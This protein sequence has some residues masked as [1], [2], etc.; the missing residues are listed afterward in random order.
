MIITKVYD[1]YWDGTEMC[2][3]IDNQAI[4]ISMARFAAN[5]V[6]PRQRLVFDEERPGWYYE[7][8]YETAIERGASVCV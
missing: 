3:G 2:I 7:D 8:Q 4:Y 1:T 5:P 6:S